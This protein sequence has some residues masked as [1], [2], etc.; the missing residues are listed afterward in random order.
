MK[1]SSGV[2]RIQYAHVQTDRKKPAPGAG[3]TVAC[4]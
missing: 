1:M 3:F 2:R 4:E